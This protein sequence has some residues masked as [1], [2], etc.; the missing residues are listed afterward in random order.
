MATAQRAS[1]FHSIV[2]SL[3]QRVLRA[4]CNTRQPVAIFAGWEDLDELTAT[5]RGME[6]WNAIRAR[7]DVRAFTDQRISDEDLDRILEAGRRSPSSRNWQP[8]DF[9]VVTDRAQLQ[10]LS[11]VWRGGGHVAG[12]AAT[13]ALVG[14]VL[15]DDDPHRRSLWYDLGQASMSMMIAAADLGIGSGHSA[16]ADQELARTVLGFP[17][18]R[19]CAYLIPLGYPADRPLR[20]IERP[21]RRPFDTLVHRERW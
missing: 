15:A 9:I 17:S 1:I 11:R 16:V 18:D 14:P 6:T 8:W 4:L 21:D 7:R 5:L 10:D 2:F 12:S 19:L 13:V 3:S 20:P